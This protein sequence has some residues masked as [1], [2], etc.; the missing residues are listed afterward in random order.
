MT[1]NPWDSETSKSKDSKP[2]M[3]PKDNMYLHIIVISLAILAAFFGNELGGDGIKYATVK[4]PDSSIGQVIRDLISGLIIAYIPYALVYL[5]SKI[6]PYAIYV[7]L[8]WVLF[9]SYIKFLA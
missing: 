6:R 8:V 9:Y 2:T 5:F 4:Q 1:D 7:T 3:K